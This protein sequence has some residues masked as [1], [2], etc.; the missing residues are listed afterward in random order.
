MSA[1][2]QLAV[3]LFA[4]LH[5]WGEGF[6]AE[7]F[8][9]I[10]VDL[11]DMRKELGQPR[12]DGLELI[13]QDVLTLHGSQFKDAAVIVASPPC[14]EFSY[15]AMP[16]KKAKAQTPDVLPPWWKKTESE[17][18]AFELREWMDWKEKY[19]LPSPNL[20][21]FNACF[22][23]QREASEAAGRHIP[24]IVEN[25]KGAQRWVRRAQAHF[26]SFFLWGDLGQVGNRVVV[27]N[28]PLRDAGLRPRTRAQKV[29][30]FRFDGSGKS[31]QSASVKVSGQDWSRF[32]N[33]GEV[34]P[35][36]RMEGLKT[37]HI[38]IEDAGI[39]LQ[40]PGHY[41]KPGSGSDWYDGG[42]AAYGSNSVQRKAAS[43]RIA[44]IPL[45]LARYIARAFK[46]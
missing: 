10:G 19:P 27:L 45:P 4:G 24:L 42:A 36:W 9:V 43:A 11:V 29:P 1:S 41:R 21:L 3:D 7:G 6:L 34:S 30:G 2:S 35:H 17:M 22:R 40:S 46:P 16:W 33:T 31:F 28:G 37:Q 5:G 20:D 23:I 38:R 15:R 39:K 32:A 25:V 26:G 8:K 14:Q 12:L 18:D 13:L 44:K